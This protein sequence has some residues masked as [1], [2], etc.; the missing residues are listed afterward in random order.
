MLNKLTHLRAL[1]RVLSLVLGTIVLIVFQLLWMLPQAFM[2]KM[3]RRQSPIVRLW[4]RF[5]L[6]L[7]GIKVTVVNRR[8]LT[9]KQKIILSNH[10]SY[11]D[12]LVLGAYF[13][14]F[15]VAKMDIAGWPIFGF[16]AKV[17]GTVF[18]TRQRQHVLRQLEL[19]QKHVDA[20]QSLLI[21]PEGTTSDGTHVQ[22]F[23]SSLL[24]CAFDAKKPPLIQ[25][26]S[27]I[28]THMN[29]HKLQT[30]QDYDHV[31]WYGD[32]TLVPH[33]WRAF[34]QKK[35][36][37][38]VIIHPTLKVNEETNPKKMAADAHA[39]VNDGF[40]HAFPG[41][42]EALPIQFDTPPAPQAM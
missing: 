27:L 36:N 7:L 39:L 3:T 26:V 8:N 21:F 6:F 40:I 12:I 2:V 23:K 9:K 22:N 17:G 25:P 24:N 32:M 19:L 20:R 37:A 30:Q 10:I 42:E 11:M 35:F 13:D 28:Y 34:R 33:L 16:L 14:C 31:A 4:Y 41:K 29:G 15:F 5:V 1:I 18:I 38:K